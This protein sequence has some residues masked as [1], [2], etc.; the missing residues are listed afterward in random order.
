MTREPEQAIAALFD[1]A[2]TIRGVRVLAAVLDGADDD[3]CKIVLRLHV[4]AEDEI[5]MLADALLTHLAVLMDSPRAAQARERI[6]A[7]RGMLREVT[8][9]SSQAGATE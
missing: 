6:E 7:A 3:R 1:Y 9:Q 4:G 5:A 8:Q 2:V